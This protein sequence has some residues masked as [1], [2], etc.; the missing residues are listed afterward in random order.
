MKF[1]IIK[2][3]VETLK[4]KKYIFFQHWINT[5]KEYSCMMQ[6]K[7]KHLCIVL[8]MIISMKHFPNG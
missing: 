1:V 7:K 8:E 6:K 2:S 4:G 3:K 5:L